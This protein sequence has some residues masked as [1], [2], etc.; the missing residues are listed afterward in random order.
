MEDG[1]ETGAASF[2]RMCAGVAAYTVPGHGCSGTVFQGQRRKRE[3]ESMEIREFAEKVR[4][5]VEKEL[6]QNYQVELKRIKKN[7]G[8]VLHGLVILSEG[9][10]IVPAVYLEAFREAY[11]SGTDFAE[12]VRKLIAVYER[13][14]LDI[15]IDMEFFRTF[16]L[17]KDR[18]CYRLVG[19]KGN[20][21]LLEDVPY[22]EFLDLALCFYYAFQGKTLG[23]GSILVH[24]SHMEMWG[25]TT[26]ELVKLAV[27]NT[28][29]LFPWDCSS[30]EEVLEEEAGIR[31]SREAGEEPGTGDFQQAVSMKVL[32]NVKRVQGAVC[33]LYPGVLESI[34]SKEQKSLYILPS[35]IHEVILLTDT[36]RGNAKELREMVADVN[37][38]Q[39]APEE[40]LSDSLYYYDI[41]EKRV[42]IIF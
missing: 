15:R 33:M 14:S 25:T 21:E 20:E 39:V 6:G 28:P 41:N 19:R 7:N 36:G 22:V 27:C 1:P 18:I 9:K 38:T 11:E 29:R 10:S 3:N 42:K 37:R 31:I 17:V 5:A 2:P 23:E 26:A 35:S 4:S 40:V 16:A 30:L 12:I 8:I 13:D 34:A 32:S 24:N